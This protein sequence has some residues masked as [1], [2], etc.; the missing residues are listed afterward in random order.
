VTMQLLLNLLI[1]MVWMLLHDEWN[2]L[3][4]T[5]GFLL[6]FLIIFSVRRFFPTPFYGRKLWSIMKLIYLFSIDLVV[7]SVLVIGQIIRP[8]LN[9][10]PGIFK[11]E[12]KL[13]SEWELSMLVNLLTLTPGSV[14]ME[15]EL[16]KGLLYVHTMDIHKL[17]D[18][19]INTKNKLEDVIIEVMR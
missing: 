5:V 2:M 10:Q 7:S 14:I 15:I 12:T 3:T 18:S 13:K 1:A 11:M 19:V 6:G 17:Q 16:E 8:K 4:F 9:I